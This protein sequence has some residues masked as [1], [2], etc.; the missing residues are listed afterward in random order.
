[1]A[2]IGTVWHEF[3]GAR[4][5]KP[6][7]YG[8]MSVWEF[9]FYKAFHLLRDGCALPAS[10]RPPVS[11][12]S[13]AEASS[14]LAIL[15]RMSDEDYYLTTRKL[16]AEFDRR[17]NLEKPP[18]S[19][20]RW[21]AESQRSEEILWLER[22]LKPKRPIAEIAG[23]KIWRDLLRANTYADVRK[24]CGRWSR[25]P[26][27]LGAG[28]TPFPD[29][30]RT[31][32]AQF[33]AMKRNKRFPKSAYGDDARIEFLARGMAGIMVNRSPLTGVERLRNMRHGPDGPLG[34]KQ[35]GDRQLPRNQQHCGCWRCRISRGN[36]LT[37]TMQTAYDN[38]FRLF[39]QIAASTKAPKEWTDR[40]FH[41]GHLRRFQK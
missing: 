38:G 24:V 14:F 9:E 13:R 27:V 19:V 35:E 7:D 41:A 15:K 11:G 40:A 30:V 12:L 10:R 28:L 3:M 20:D 1:M 23:M 34:V 6:V 21:W 26:A 33:I 2:W 16:G 31:N 8:L 17:V 22:L 18:I 25:L 32:A 39:M 4:G 36:K 37:K 5:P 29:H